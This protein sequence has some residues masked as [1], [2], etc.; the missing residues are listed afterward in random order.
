M[1]SLNVPRAEVDRVVRATAMHLNDV[2]GTGPYFQRPL[3]PALGGRITSG[4]FAPTLAALALTPA[5]SVTGS[6]ETPFGKTLSVLAGTLERVGAAVRVDA[7]GSFTVAGGAGASLTMKIKLGTY[8]LYT[9]PAVAL[10]AAA[11]GYWALQVFTQLRASSLISHMLAGQVGGNVL[12]IDR[13]IHTLDSTA[14]STLRANAQHLVVTAQWSN[15]NA[16]GV[17]LDLAAAVAWDGALSE[18]P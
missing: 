2:G 17:T 15:A 6:S 18:T 8:T 9:S 12:A 7:A 4:R 1:S 14:L 13:S 11:T 3:S 5:T 10:L 16:N